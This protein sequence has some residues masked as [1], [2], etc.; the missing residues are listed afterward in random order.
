MHIRKITQSTSPRKA[1]LEDSIA[2]VH[3]IL[4]LLVTFKDIVFYDTTDS[5]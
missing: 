4:H 5:D 3:D 1:D 2:I